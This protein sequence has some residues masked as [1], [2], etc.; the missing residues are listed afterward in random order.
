MER[1]MTSGTITRWI[2]NIQDDFYTEFRDMYTI[3]DFERMYE[4]L[5]LCENKSNLPTILAELYKMFTALDIPFEKI[6]T[7]AIIA[8]W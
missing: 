7:I 4:K 3:T 5:K 1:F 6:K 2:S 8:H